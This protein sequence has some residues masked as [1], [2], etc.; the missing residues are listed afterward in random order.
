MPKPPAP[1]VA[2][3]FAGRAPSV[4]ATY[5]AITAAARKLGPVR[6]E[7]KKTSIHLAR[8]TAFAGV[9]T[10]RASLIL[11]LKSASN[12]ESPRVRRREQ[13]SANRWH[14]EIE[15]AAPADVDHEL[16][17]WLGAAYELAR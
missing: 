15:L 1:R 17:Q 14:L 3:H 10:R 4:K 16:R 8:R 2:E 7:P 12:L 9:A 13:A 5:Q 6:E 11:T